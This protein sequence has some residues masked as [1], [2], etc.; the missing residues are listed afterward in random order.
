MNINDPTRQYIAAHA[1]DNVARLA[2]HPTKDPQVDMHVA[3]QQI[4]GRQKA[5][6]KL[7]EWYA[8]EGILYPKR[9]SLEQCSSS[10]T[11]DYKASVAEGETFADF[12]GGFGVDTVAFARKFGQGIYVEPQQELCELFCHNSKIL[13]INNIQVINGIMEEQL[14]S[15]GAVDMI[16]LDPSRRDPDGRR[17]VSISDCTPN[18]LEWKSALL[19]KCSTLMVKLSPMIDIR[20]T[21]R[22]LPETFAVHVV[23]VEGECKEAVFLLSREKASAEQG[24]R[25]CAT[26]HGT[27]IVAADIV[28]GAV[29]RVETTV[30][31]ERATP[32]RIATALGAYLYEP[33]AAVMKAGISNTV[34]ERFR[35]AKVAHNTNLFT[36]DELR[37]GFPGRIFHVNAVREFH[38]RKMA[39][40]PLP[41]TSASVAVRN[42]P[43][44]AE[45]LRKTLKIKDGDTHYLFGCTLSD[46]R[47]V[48]VAC[49]RM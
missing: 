34:S 45:E 4:A 32:P 20:Q 25:S 18:L 21:L 28:N 29:C 9:V 35:V 39:K 2:L 23:A 12:S 36:S 30:D 38:P 15:V 6:E 3:L 13:G 8:A 33:N 41:V 42:F 14:G 37:E 19:D 40:E 43:L 27:A 5:K 47:R 10:Q 16:Y 46:N 26:G 7:P 49:S 44:S 48:V 31:A 11:A 1:S 22:D 24:G 17:V